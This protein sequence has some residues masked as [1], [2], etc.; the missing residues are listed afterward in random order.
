MRDRGVYLIYEWLKTYNQ[1]PVWHCKLGAGASKWF[2]GTINEFETM[3]IMQISPGYSCFLYINTLGMAPAVQ[4]VVIAYH[5][6]Q[7]IHWSHHRGGS[8]DRYVPLRAGLSWNHRQAEIRLSLSLHQ[9]Q[10]MERNKFLLDRLLQFRRKSYTA[11]S[12]RRTQFWGCSKSS[13]PREK[14]VWRRTKTVRRR[15]MS[16]CSA[17]S[18][19]TAGR[20]SSPRCVTSLG[21][22]VSWPGPSMAAPPRAGSQSS[23]RIARIEMSGCQRRGWG[24][25]TLCRR[26]T[27]RNEHLIQAYLLLITLNYKVS[28]KILS[29][30]IYVRMYFVLPSRS[31]G[32]SYPWFSNN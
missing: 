29:V 22:V 11:L 23:R 25:I 30:W 20:R 6:R 32:I 8:T 1:S 18:A 19:R 5:V 3:Y 16:R 12:F 9:L 24:V 26:D 2:T 10:E 15:V 4:I 31:M 13:S 28:C 14:I 21:S 17:I 7:F 27:R